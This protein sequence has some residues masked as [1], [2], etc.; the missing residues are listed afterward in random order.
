MFFKDINKD[1]VF[2]NIFEQECRQSLLTQNAINV[3]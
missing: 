3:K 1:I 2:K